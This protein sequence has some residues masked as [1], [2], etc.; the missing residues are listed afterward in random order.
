MRV[1]GRFLLGT[2]AI[3]FAMGFIARLVRRRP[4][5]ERRTARLTVDPES[6][7]AYLA[8]QPGANGWG[9]LVVPPSLPARAARRKGGRSVGG[10]SRRRRSAPS[11]R[12]ARV[13]KS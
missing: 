7:Q 3:V 8:A 9:R 5:L 11:A 6:V 13:R 2:L 1:I 10:S 4:L 12:G